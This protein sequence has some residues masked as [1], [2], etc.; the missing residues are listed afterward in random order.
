MTKVRKNIRM[1][2]AEIKALIP[3]SSINVL[4]SVT[5]IHQPLRFVRIEIYRIKFNDYPR[6][7]SRAKW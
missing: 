3:S 4:R 7:R 2:Y 5:M 1:G 6:E